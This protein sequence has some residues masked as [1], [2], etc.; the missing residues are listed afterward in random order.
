MLEADG[1]VEQFAETER[2]VLAARMRFYDQFV[3]QDG[4]GA[5]AR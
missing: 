3:E 2:R 1:D 5:G 4:A